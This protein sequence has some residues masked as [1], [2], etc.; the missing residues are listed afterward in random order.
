MKP[1]IESKVAVLSLKGRLWLPPDCET[2]ETLLGKL[3]MYHNGETRA[4]HRGKQHL[5]KHVAL[6]NQ[7]KEALHKFINLNPNEPC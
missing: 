3:W 2:T 4:F 6:R 5:R 1:S 7:A